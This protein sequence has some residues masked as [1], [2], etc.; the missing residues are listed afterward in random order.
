MHKETKGVSLI[1]AFSLG[2]ADFIRLAVLK[3]ANSLA[4]LSPA[5]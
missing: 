2:K 1:A 3:S 4:F 5:R